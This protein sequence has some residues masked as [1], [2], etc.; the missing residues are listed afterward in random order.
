MTN[1]VLISCASKKL[2]HTAKA[3]DMYIS[4]LFKKNLQYAK[5]LLKPEKIYILSAKHGLLKLETEIEHYNKTLNNMPSRDKTKWAENVYKQLK[6]ETDINTSKYIFL[7]GYNYYKYLVQKLPCYEIL[8]EGLQIGKHLQWL[9][10]KLN[11][12]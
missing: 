4:S 1:I 11:E 2:G 3:Q 12:C 10:E 9:K 5:D 6:K 7:A 8:M